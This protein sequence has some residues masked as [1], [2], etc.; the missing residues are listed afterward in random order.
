MVRNKEKQHMVIHV[1]LPDPGWLAIGLVPLG[2]DI[3]GIPLP[4][5]R[6]HGPAA[7]MV[8]Q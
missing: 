2:G 4:G 1:V 6:T 7:T 5:V 8:W 3:Q